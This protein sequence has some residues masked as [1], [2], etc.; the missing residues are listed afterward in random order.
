MYLAFLKQQL[1]K[2]KV[3]VNKTR[4]S[5]YT[6]T[7]LTTCCQVCNRILTLRVTTNSI[8]LNEGRGTQ[9]ETRK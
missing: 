5:K 4:F 2:V 3:Y 8:N 6:I 1:L 9:Y 7:N